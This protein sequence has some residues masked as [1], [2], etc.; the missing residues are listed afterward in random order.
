MKPR[1]PFVRVPIPAGDTLID[2][3]REAFTLLTSLRG[4][5]FSKTKRGLSH[6]KNQNI[7]GDQ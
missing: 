4:F 6:G 5:L 1:Q 7:A 2:E 3:E